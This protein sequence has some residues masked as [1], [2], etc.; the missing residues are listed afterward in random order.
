MSRAHVVLS[1]A[2]PHVRAPQVIAHAPNEQAKDEHHQH[3][4][5]GFAF[6]PTVLHY[7]IP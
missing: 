2:A 4:E 6:C 5:A 7:P 3:K 1:C